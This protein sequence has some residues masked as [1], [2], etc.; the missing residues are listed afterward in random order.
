M[1]KLT[2]LLYLKY[3]SIHI[4]QTVPRV[5]LLRKCR[6]LHGA[7]TDLKPA[8][9]MNDDDHEKATQLVEA[10]QKL[11]AMSCDRVQQVDLPIVEING[12]GANEAVVACVRHVVEGGLVPDVWREV[13]EMLDV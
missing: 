8:M 3:A 6:V 5:V 12:E 4:L 7:T 10:R 11:G 9:E 2:Q 1:R 13:L